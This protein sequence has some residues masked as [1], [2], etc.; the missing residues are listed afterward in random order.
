MP[1]LE[2]MN[3]RVREEITDKTLSFGCRMDWKWIMLSEEV[4]MYWDPH[5]MGN[6]DIIETT[7]FE[8]E[9]ILGHPP[10]IWVVMQWMK[11]LSPLH[12]YV[13]YEWPDTDYLKLLYR[14]PKD[15][16]SEPLPNPWE[17]VW[18]EWRD[19]LEFLFWLIDNEK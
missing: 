8:D 18:E 7:D 13:D 11:E 2:Q 19:V 4:I 9:E 5:S 10:H 3:T 15:K 17:S 1:S 14:R 12:P 16:L 6:W